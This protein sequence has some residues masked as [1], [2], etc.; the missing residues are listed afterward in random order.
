LS[1]DDILFCNILPC[2]DMPMFS[3]AIFPNLSQKH[4]LGFAQDFCLDLCFCGCCPG[5]PFAKGDLDA[6]WDAVARQCPAYCWGAVSKQCLCTWDSVDGCWCL[7]M[8][9]MLEVRWLLGFMLGFTKD[10]EGPWSTVSVICFALFR[11]L[12]MLK[13]VEEIQ[14]L[15]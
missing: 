2:S 13:K 15:R 9:V 14:P 5:E 6:E 7:L 10:V 4:W 12:M 8:H 11:A 1:S 3:H